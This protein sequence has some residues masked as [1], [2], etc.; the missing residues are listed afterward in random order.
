MDKQLQWHQRNTNN[1]SKARKNTQPFFKSLN[2][3]CLFIRNTGSERWQHYML[4]HY[5]AQECVHFGWHGMRT[6]IIMEVEWWRPDNPGFQR[7]KHPMEIRT[8][9]PKWSRLASWV[10]H[11]KISCRVTCLLQV[12]DLGTANSSQCL[13]YRWPVHLVVS[14]PSTAFI[15]HSLRGTFSTLFIVTSLLIHNRFVKES[16]MF[17][18]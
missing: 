15:P 3:Q 9:H 4:Q 8:T 14:P 7:C 2:K 16:S 1:I 6:G 10:E 12:K 18:F 13:I 11:E 17:A 5:Y